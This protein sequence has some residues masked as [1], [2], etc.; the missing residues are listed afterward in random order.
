[1]QNEVLTCKNESCS[2][3]LYAGVTLL[4]VLVD[5]ETYSINPSEN[6]FEYTTDTGCLKTEVKN[7]TRIFVSKP[8]NALCP[9]CKGPAIVI[10]ASLEIGGN[11]EDI[12][13]QIDDLEKTVDDLLQQCGVR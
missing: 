12:L 8:T 10:C 3:Y 5:G 4:D 7:E 6:F 1:M 2:L 13:K 11:K 9:H